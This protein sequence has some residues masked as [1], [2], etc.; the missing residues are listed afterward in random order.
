MKLTTAL[1]RKR[2]GVILCLAVAGSLLQAQEAQGTLATARSTWF[3]T[4]ATFPR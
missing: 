2:V 4:A 1:T 3:R